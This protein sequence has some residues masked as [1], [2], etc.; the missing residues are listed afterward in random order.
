MRRAKGFTLV[1]LL[2]VI[3]IISILAS[4]A[5]PN[6]TQYLS[7]ARMTKAQAEINSI[8][9]A[10]TAILA[11]SGR[12]DFS[13]N[14]FFSSFPPVANIEAA[15]E[16]YTEAFYLIMKVGNDAGSTDFAFPAGVAIHNDIRRSLGNTYMDELGNDPWGNRYLI[17]PGPWSTTQGD[18][19]FRRVAR[20]DNAVGERDDDSEVTY[21]DPDTATVIETGY[22]APTT[23][24]FYI[25]SPGANLVSNQ[26]SSLEY[27][28]LLASP[29]GIAEPDF[30]GGGDDVNNWDNQESY[31]R[32][33]R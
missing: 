4:I 13:R 6:I 16:I 31:A 32:F 5:V 9:T 15:A 30:V 18:I 26:L 21:E 28:N 33:Y 17:Y 7:R 22:P 23:K 27:Q 2:V 10:L 29:G 8:E 19:E 12:R 3:A 11:D 20:D 1:E 25:W 14:S 24:P